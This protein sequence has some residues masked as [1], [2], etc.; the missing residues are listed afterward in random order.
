MD[1][2]V[3]LNVYDS[4]CKLDGK[5]DTSANIKNMIFLQREK[6]EASLTLMCL[7]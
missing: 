5:A 7:F 6:N 2:Y 4:S 3:C 1:I